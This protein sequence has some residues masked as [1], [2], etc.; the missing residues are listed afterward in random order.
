[1]PKSKRIKN[2]INKLDKG[3]DLEADVLMAVI[4]DAVESYCPDDKP[5]HWRISYAKLFKF[6][7]Q[8]IEKYGKVKI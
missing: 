7:R 2:K 5:T 3:D 4:Y 1:M 8:M 6:V